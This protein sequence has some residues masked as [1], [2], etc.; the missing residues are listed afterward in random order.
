M[1]AEFTVSICRSQGEHIRE[2][3]FLHEPLTLLGELQQ[4]E[5]VD[6]LA[7]LVGIAYCYRRWEGPD[8]L[9]HNRIVLLDGNA[10][11]S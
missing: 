9:D 6:F 1:C 5:A 4:S 8:F 2:N 7:G 10:S 3:E 11:A